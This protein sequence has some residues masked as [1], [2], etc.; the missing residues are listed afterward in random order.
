M[1]QNRGKG[2][3]PQKYSQLTL[4]TERNIM[5]NN[6]QQMDLERLTSMKK[7]VIADTGLIYNNVKLK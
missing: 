1:G 3:R 4:C 7:K 5:E 2:N 6:L